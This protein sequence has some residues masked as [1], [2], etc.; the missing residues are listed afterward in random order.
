MLDRDRSG[1]TVS[2]ER[3]IRTV[4]GRAASESVLNTI[5]RQHRRQ[6]EPDAEETGPEPPLQRWVAAGRSGAG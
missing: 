5:A 2:L 6:E 4:S 3:L 1:W